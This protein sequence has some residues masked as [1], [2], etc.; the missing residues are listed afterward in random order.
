MT[1]VDCPFCS[2]AAHVEGQLDAIACDGCGITTE[3]ADD[4]AD[5]LDAAA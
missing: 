4:G 2:D 3:V 1:T 5:I